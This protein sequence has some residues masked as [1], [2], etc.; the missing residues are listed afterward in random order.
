MEVA[1]DTPRWRVYEVRQQDAFGYD[2]VRY[3]LREE[4]E[5]GATRCIHN[6]TFED[7]AE[8]QTQ[9]A[10]FNLNAK[11]GMRYDNIMKTWR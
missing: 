10:R 4:Y 11:K 9:A 5:D 6:E 8:A 2:R 1:T 3:G 7:E